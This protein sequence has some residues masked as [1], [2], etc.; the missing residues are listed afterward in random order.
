MLSELLLELGAEIQDP[1]EESFLLFSQ[2]VPSQNLGFIDPKAKSLEL[3]VAG[4]DLVIQQSPSIFSSDREEGT[5]GAVVWKIAPLF[6]NW[7]ASDN[8]FL[9]KTS[10][11]H[12]NSNVLELGCGI[13]GIVG[14]ALSPKIRRYIATDQDYVFKML[15]LNLEDNL[16]K[17]KSHKTGQRR[18]G[19]PAA[20]LSANLSSTNIK[21]VHL[22]WETSL[23]SPILFDSCFSGLNLP[24]GTS[25][26]LILACDCIFNEALI[27][28][29][30]RTCVD[31]CRLPK[32]ES[33]RRS[34]CIIA[35]QLRSHMV[36]EAWLFAF[37]QNFRVWRVPDERLHEDM[38]G[39]SGFV[40]HLGL[41][42]EPINSCI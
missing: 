12:S 30:V 20:E 41:L 15:K 14:L 28:P 23:I 18:K 10:I 13:S 27:D 22:D 42:R 17:P 40:I 37:H 39:G 29:F 16:P 3:E 7:V 35:Q 21:I 6:A 1:E 26:D 24:Q 38:R 9:F 25:L 19:K 2:R 34:V 33:S 4:R 31:L 11:L 36:F 32:A 8:N 5:T